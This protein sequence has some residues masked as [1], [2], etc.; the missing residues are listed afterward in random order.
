MTHSPPRRTKNLIYVC[1]N[2]IIILF[3]Y[4]INNYNH[5]GRNRGFQNGI[6]F[7]KIPD[8]LLGLINVYRNSGS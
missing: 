8:Q 1:C 2:N 6:G 3:I 4:L 7:S 5:F